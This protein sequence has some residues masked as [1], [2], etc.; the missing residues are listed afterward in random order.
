MHVCVG[1]YY[2]FVLQIHVETSTAVSVATSVRCLSLQERHTVLLSVGLT[3]VLQ[4]SSVPF[5]LLSL[6]HV[7]PVLER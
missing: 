2:C 5:N 1:M 6:A 4:G 7:N 3:R